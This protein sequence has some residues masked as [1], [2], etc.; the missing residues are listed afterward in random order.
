[1]KTRDALASLIAV[2]FAWPCLGQQLLEVPY[3]IKRPVKD[4]NTGIMLTNQPGGTIKGTIWMVFAAKD[5]IQ[6]FS[7]SSVGSSVS[8]FNFMDAFYV[9]EEQ[10]DKIKAVEASYVKITSLMPGA[11]D[12]TFWF[13]KSDMLLWN[14]C[15]IQSNVVIG[16]FTSEFNKEV[17]LIDKLDDTKPVTNS[18]GYFS[19]PESDNSNKISDSREFM[20]L[21]VYKEDHGFYLLGPKSRLSRTTYKQ[22]ING[23]MS[24][25]FTVEYFN[26]FAFE[27]NWEHCNDRYPVKVFSNLD[28]AKKYMDNPT[29]QPGRNEGEIIFTENPMYCARQTGCLERFYLLDIV[30][31][32]TGK[33]PKVGI[34]GNVQLDNLQ[35]QSDCFSSS[36]D[37]L[38]E[39]RIRDKFTKGFNYIK[40]VNILFVVDATASME[41]YRTSIIRA[42]TQTMGDILE[43]NKAEEKDLDY[44]FG[45]V[46]FRDQSE[47]IPIEFSNFGDWTDDISVMVN[48]FGQAIDP[49]KNGRDSDYPEALYYGIQQA[50][51][52]F[53]VNP[54]NTNYLILIGDACNNPASFPEA[55]ETNVVELLDR[56]N[57]NLLTYQIHYQQHKSNAFADFRTQIDRITQQIA[58]RKNE[59]LWN[60]YNTFV[61]SCPATRDVFYEFFK[62]FPTIFIPSIDMTCSTDNNTNKVCEINSERFPI[63]TMTYYPH[64]SVTVLRLQQELGNSLN[65]IAI[66]TEETINKLGRTLEWEGTQLEYQARVIYFCLSLGLSLDEIIFLLMPAEQYFQVG[67]TCYQPSWSPYPLFNYV[68]LIGHV[69]VQQI[70]DF[71]NDMVPPGKIL[72]EQVLRE[73]IYNIWKKVLVSELNLISLENFD[74]ATL[75]QDITFL[76]GMQ[77]PEYLKSFYN[78]D[79]LYSTKF[80]ADKLYAH[81]VD[82]IITNAY[83]QSLMNGKNMLNQQYFKG[84]SACIRRYLEYANTPEQPSS[85]SPERQDEYFAL[86]A[87]KFSGDEEYDFD[88]ENFPK[89]PYMNIEPTKPDYRYFWYYW[90]DSRIFPTEFTCGSQIV[91][92]TAREF[93]QH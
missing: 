7:S 24:E 88:E 56:K 47:A 69:Q 31:D 74:D 52:T 34:R 36:I 2:L 40:R 64:D 79:I 16:D 57:F 13:N 32:S 77:A 45:A 90:L 28:L 27:M 33:Y 76:S 91:L 49:T 1:M 38:K 14:N 53:D 4:Y 46:I 86:L 41:A 87:Q 71:I 22:D 81:C 44:Q 10:Q 73:H 19:S 78:K 3:C 18:P 54:L 51:D 48:F 5:K 43:K 75:A 66:K 39:A 37:P 67:Y 68:S 72:N 30:T 80:S 50:I 65:N 35:L 83:L 25:D 84:Y 12:H 60:D 61:A 89:Y 29:Y 55:T 59:R 20:L 85:L 11:N 82:L 93:L 63:I 58:V 6:G 9:V 21:F 42:L 92:E 23:W 17:L 15:L 8:T 70:Q 26:H 62:N